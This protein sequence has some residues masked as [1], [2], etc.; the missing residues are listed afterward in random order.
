MNLWWT[1]LFLLNFFK[2]ESLLKIEIKSEVNRFFSIQSEILVH[3]LSG[4]LNSKI[5][6]TTSKPAA[7]KFKSLD[8]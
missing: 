5:D 6:H 4:E 3:F 1:T 7:T 8:G 2:I